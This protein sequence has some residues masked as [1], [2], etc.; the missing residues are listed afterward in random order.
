MNMEMQLHFLG[1]VCL[2]G[3]TLACSTQAPGP[4]AAPDDPDKGKAWIG[5]Q[6]KG[7]ALTDEAGVQVDLS[8]EFGKRPVV[9]VFY[10]GV[11]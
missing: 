7:V 3:L 9:L 11:W 5:T 4:Q 1:L 2:A 10:R 6:A 8:K